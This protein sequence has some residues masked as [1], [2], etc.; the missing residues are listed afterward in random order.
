MEAVKTEIDAAPTRLQSPSPKTAETAERNRR[1]SLSPQ[2][3]PYL[4]PPPAATTNGIPTPPPSLEVNTTSS[5]TPPASPKLTPAPEP[6]PAQ[7]TGDKLQKATVAEKKEESESRTRA[8][9]LAGNNV[10]AAM[11]LL[12]PPSPS[13]GL[14]RATKLDDDQQS[15]EVHQEKA[16]A[17]LVNSNVQSVNNSLL[18]GGSCSAGSPGVHVTLSIHCR[19][20]S[21]TRGSGATSTH[22]PHHPSLP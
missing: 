3:Q 15:K 7:A 6:K 9:I 8:I 4:P 17:T 12:G 21:K 18:L 20:P 16:M 19:R 5:P 10:G 13:Y 11:D 2:P 22:K 14:R 1:R